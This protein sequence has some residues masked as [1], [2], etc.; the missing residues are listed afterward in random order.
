MIDTKTYD[1][2]LSYAHKDVEGHP[3][4]ERYLK[5][6]KGGI[7]RL[8]G[9]PLVFLDSES[10]QPGETWNS[11]IMV[12]IHSCKVFL[13]LLSRNYL[14]SEYCKREYLWWSKKELR[15]GR[16][17]KMTLPIYYV[18]FPEDIDCVA[19]SSEL[20][21]DLLSF[22]LAH[23]ARPW[24][25]DGENAFQEALIRERLDAVVSCTDEFLA[26][27]TKDL[28]F[29]SVAPY[30]P[31]FVGR[32][33]ELRKLWELCRSG[34]YPVIHANA[35][36]GKTDLA[37]AYVH[38]FADEYPQGRFEVKMSGVSSWAE[39]INRLLEGVEMSASKPAISAKDLLGVTD[40]ILPVNLEERA[41]CVWRLIEQRALKGPLVLLLDNLDD[42]TLLG[43]RGWR[44]LVQREYSPNIH[45][46]VTT[47]NTP[48]LMESSR[49]VSFNLGNLDADAA[50]ELLRNYCKNAPI[51][52]DKPQDDDDPECKAARDLA[53]LL[54][55]H[56]WSLTIVGGDVG[57][58]WRGGMTFKKKFEA[59]KDHFKIGSAEVL[60]DQS[61][62]AIAKKNVGVVAIE[63]LQVASL[64]PPELIPLALIGEY[65]NKYLSMSVSDELGEGYCC[66]FLLDVLRRYHLLTCTCVAEDQPIPEDGF[67][68]MHR[69]TWFCVRSKYKLNY[70][71]VLRRAQDVLFPYVEKQS[72]KYGSG[73]T[74]VSPERDAMIVS[75]IVPIY[76]ELVKH[77][78]REYCSALAKALR[79]LA[80]IKRATDDNVAAKS[81]N[82]EAVAIYRE[83]VKTDPS[84]YIPNLARALCA[85]GVVHEHECRYGE[86]QKRYEEAVGL[87]D[88]LKNRAT[89][90]SEFDV[91]VLKVN[92]GNLLSKTM[93]LAESYKFY[94]D[95]V[96]VGRRL[97]HERNIKS[98]PLLVIALKNLGVEKMADGN[99]DDA[100][101]FLAEALLHARAY[102]F[103]E[104][105]DCKTLIFDVL[106]DI[107]ELQ[108][109]RG[110]P[111]KANEC[112]EECLRIQKELVAGERG[113]HLAGLARALLNQGRGMMSAGDYKGAEFCIL[114]SISYFRELVGKCRMVHLPGLGNALNTLGSVYFDQGAYTR[115]KE[116]FLSA[117][118]IRKELVAFNR[119]AFS[120]ALI[121]SLENL[122]RVQRILGHLQDAQRVL[123]S[124][125]DVC[126]KF[127]R[128]HPDRYESLLSSVMLEYGKLLIADGRSADDVFDQANALAMRHQNNPT[129]KKVLIGL[130]RL[131]ARGACDEK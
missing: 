19:T 88:D 69:I 91:A 26:R 126:Q 112:Y 66:Q 102:A 40:E 65:F 7:E 60:L 108:R 49:F 122:G 25:I 119:L 96:A 56:A 1:V 87:W 109:R 38:G 80:N 75:A 8:A 70:T 36:V 59:I 85:M 28:G 54:E 83:L 17:R 81:L 73:R 18:Q 29:C 107:G 61:F 9:K 32:L 10:I 76:R 16:L 41:Q 31:D 52:L 35:G 64:F 101:R 43:K 34:R 104:P 12:G 84:T 116:P 4:R 67:V 11:K 129:C 120:R 123:A 77:V 45:I 106:T 21:K 3:E 74:G 117:V 79:L 113:S 127:V 30:N 94:L 82:E 97:L 58:N 71:Y 90:Y 115:A 99:L 37:R 103:H 27:T 92:L 63:L 2:F 110:L 5:E 100:D 86:A 114:E 20:A 24:F 121:Q 72:G 13:C 131:R 125:I 57:E 23:G 46:V 44:E 118:E 62:A 53:N 95:A 48:V 51:N 15:S 14:N 105:T 22:Q 50:I 89:G 47:R 98:Y 124:A 42:M 6:L 33:V 78:G 39:A 93:N 130:K 55:N 68:S 111:V 128:D